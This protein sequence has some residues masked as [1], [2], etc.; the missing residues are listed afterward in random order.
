MYVNNEIKLRMISVGKVSSLEMFLQALNPGY[1]YAQC[2]LARFK[3]KD[4]K[5]LKY[6]KL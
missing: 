4:R 1:Q 6:R 5:P 3:T 2:S